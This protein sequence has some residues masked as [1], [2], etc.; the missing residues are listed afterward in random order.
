MPARWQDI[1]WTTGPWIAK[2]IRRF[3]LPRTLDDYEQVWITCSSF[4]DA[5]K[6]T[7]NDSIIGEW[8]IPP[9]NGIEME[10]TSLLKTRNELVVNIQSSMAN[11]GLWGEV[12]LQIRGAY[13]LRDV[14]IQDE[15]LTGSV[16]GE[17]KSPLEL[18][19]LRFGRTVRYDHVTAAP[20]GRR[21]AFA[22]PRMEFEPPVGDFPSWRIEL[23]EGA[24]RWFTVDLAEANG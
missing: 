10:V 5:S 13:F 9:A 22:L 8:S 23:V 16:V 19:V 3:G 6:W 2:L 7:L 11:G 12:A 20:D 4:S 1:G 18:Y 24:N 21:F 15:T 14:C 17:S